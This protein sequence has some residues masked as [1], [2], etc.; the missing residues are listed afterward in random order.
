MHEAHRQEGHGSTSLASAQ[1]A[2]RQEGHGSTSSAG[3]RPRPPRH[4]GKPKS[5]QTCTARSAY[6]LTVNAADRSAMDAKSVQI[7]MAD[8]VGI[9]KAL[10]DGMS[11]GPL[12]AQLVADIEHSS[13]VLEMAGRVI[14][15]TTESIQRWCS[16]TSHS[17]MRSTQQR[18]RIPCPLCTGRSR[19][20][21]S[22]Q[23]RA[24]MRHT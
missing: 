13:A 18:P 16:E 20:S 7:A 11:Q 1:P 8:L 6:V 19:W 24:R 23:C 17:S 21:R 9:Q 4:S 10:L 5:Q 2:Q 15:T 12:H 22:S 3:T 14:A